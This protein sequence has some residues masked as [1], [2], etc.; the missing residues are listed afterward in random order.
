MA[1]LLV[2]ALN[3]GELSPYMDARTDVE[4]YR[5]GCRTLEN[6]VVL[7]YGGV[8]RRAGTEYLGEAKNTDRRCRL[9]GFNFSTTTRFV[10]EFGHQY[11]R[12]WGNDSP[13]AHPAGSAWA[14]TTAY[15]IGDIVTNGGTTY[16]AVSA[17]TSAASFS[18]DLT[19]GR[20]YAQPASGVLEFPSPYQ[21]SEL[22]EIQ[23]VQVND[24]MYLAH[25]NHAPRKLAR[26]ANDDWTLTAVDFKWPPLLDQ[27]ITGDTLSAARFIGDTTVTARTKGGDL[28]DNMF[29][30]GHVGSHWAIE[31]ARSSSSLTLAVDGNFVSETELDISGQWTVTT[32]GTWQGTIRLLRMSDDLVNEVGYY[33][34]GSATRS[35][36]TATV[37][38]TDHGVSTGDGL[39]I[40]YSSNTA[41]FGVTTRDLVTATRVD[42]NTFTFAV[43]NSGATSLANFT[44]QNVSRMEVVREF[45]SE[46]TARNFIATGEELTR[47]VYKLQ[48][49]NYIS[50]TS[51]RVFLESTDFT[52][53]GTFVVNSIGTAGRTANVTI[54]NFLGLRTGN[55]I[56]WSEAAFSGVR[57]YP[58]AVAIHEQRLCFGGTSHQPNTVWCSKVDDFENFQLGS[59]ADD[60]L[61]FTVASSEGNRIEWMF[62]QKRLM[63]GTSG[64]EWTIGGA[65]SGQAFSATNVQAQKQSSFGSKTMR[66]ILLN[67]VLLF[68]QRR[69]RKVRE[70]TYNFERDGWVAPD[71][72]VL[73]E[74]VTQGELVELAFQQQ[75]DAIL[76]AVRGDGQLVGMS[77]ERDQEVVAWHRHTTDGEFESV[78]TVYGLSGADDEVWLVVKRTI[79]GQTKRYIERFKA[80]NRAKFEAQTKDDWWYLDCAKR[81][82]GTATD[83]I[84]G[85]SHLEGRA[86]SVLANGAVQPDETV[87]SGQITLDKT[88]TKAL[89]GLPYTSTIL[90]MKFD[91]D[92]RDGPTR[93]R[94]KRINRVEVSLFKSLAGEASTNGTEWLW[95]YP[96]DFTDPMDASPPPFSGDAEVVV[97][98]DY[99]DDSDIYLRQRLPYPF[100]V[101]ALVVKLDAYGD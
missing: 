3:A 90:P 38:L 45:R 101:R 78:A 64:D 54:K 100:T 95:I 9:I 88:Y 30:S 62:S 28:R 99:S 76:W 84:T 25:A 87:A 46:T 57:G 69:G 79:N 47:G 6:M 2:T 91:F 61:Q 33:Q 14:T 39:F 92:L 59:S 24:I 67:D 60:G 73:S 43:A 36:T 96:R 7:P 29:T 98:G 5:S 94:K 56:R 52:N 20:W 16:Y 26:L 15:A 21:E 93:G 32:V 82:S 86:V 22:R 34:S 55:T 11:I 31:Y 89:A 23:Y 75:P 97:A 80:D 12:V 53:G 63:L 40:Y 49:V 81:Y 72:T 83:T 71:L 50:N 27:N 13:V 10:L 18:T 65:D 58:R 41:P 77:Y 44:F 85:L 66:A 37:V 48:V 68:V 17:H 19:A 70:L 42:K 35:G 74:H 51:A 4:K 1:N 8:Y